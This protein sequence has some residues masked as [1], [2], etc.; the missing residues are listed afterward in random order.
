MLCLTR[1]AGE[2]I[3]I[4]DDCFLTVIRT[5]GS[6]V[7]LGF[8]APRDLPITRDELPPVEPGNESQA[9]QEDRLSGSGV[10]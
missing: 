10:T 5:R 2:R 9:V 7:V 4:G 8:D 3:K 1:K 6:G